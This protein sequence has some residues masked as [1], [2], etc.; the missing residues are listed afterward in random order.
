MKGSTVFPCQRPVRSAR[1]AVTAPRSSPEIAPF[2][3]S[4][5][6]FVNGPLRF[7]PSQVRRP[8]VQDRIRWLLLVYQKRK[9]LGGHKL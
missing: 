6:R 4:W 9:G 5:I 1:R 2:A 3:C 8:A 7:P